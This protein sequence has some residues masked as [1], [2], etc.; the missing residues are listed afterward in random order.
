MLKVL[1]SITST[2]IGLAIIAI[3]LSP[4]VYKALQDIE[5]LLSGARII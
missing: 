4:T 5:I 2:I 3:L 1:F